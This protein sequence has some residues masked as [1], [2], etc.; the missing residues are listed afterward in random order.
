ML[1]KL[2]AS[3]GQDT[4]IFKITVFYRTGEISAL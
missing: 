3:K 4:S 1:A 2:K